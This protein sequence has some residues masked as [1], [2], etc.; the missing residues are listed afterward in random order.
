MHPK[1]NLQWSKRGGWWVKNK[2]LIGRSPYSWNIF[3][4]KRAKATVVVLNEQVCEVLGTQYRT[5]ISK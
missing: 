4:E 1:K 5:A 2:P 3:I